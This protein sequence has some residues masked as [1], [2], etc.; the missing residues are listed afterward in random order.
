MMFEKPMNNDLPRSQDWRRFLESI[1]G[2]EFVVGVASRA[3]QAILDIY[4]RPV[5]EHGVKADGSPVSEADL[6]SASLIEE[7]LGETKIPVVCEE[8]MLPDITGCSLFWL[9]DPLDGTKEFLNRNGEFC[10]NIA[11]MA[12]NEPVAGVIAVPVTGEVFVG[13]RGKGSKRV[14]NG[15]ETSITNERTTSEYIGVASRSFVS[16]EADAW[17]EQFGVA[18]I[19]RCGSAIKFCRLAEG[20]ADI[21]LRLGRTMEWDTAAGQIIIEEA[22][23]RLTTLPSRERMLYGKPTFANG[24]FIAARNDIQ[25]R[26]EPSTS[27]SPVLERASSQRGR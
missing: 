13:V 9:V 25:V 18:K 2:S 24:D 22:G 16:S 20:T 3:S 10:V 15:V 8:G 26:W 1:G 5:I 21:F 4:Q 19:L 12:G 27:L 23:C 14:L 7:A 17:L 11:L 6:A